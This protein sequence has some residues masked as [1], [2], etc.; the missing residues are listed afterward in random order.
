[1]AFKD[2]KYDTEWFRIFDTFGGTDG[3]ISFARL[4][5]FME[6]L[7]NEDSEASNTLLDIMYKF[8]RLIEAVNR[9]D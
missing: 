3:G 4:K 6:N 8:G 2:K 1:M 7:E 9:R 5:F